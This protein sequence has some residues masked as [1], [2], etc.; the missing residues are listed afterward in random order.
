MQIVTIREAVA[1]LISDKILFKTRNLT[2]VK[3]GNF[4]IMKDQHF[5]MI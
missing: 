3:E 2:R 4:I 1:K 5:R